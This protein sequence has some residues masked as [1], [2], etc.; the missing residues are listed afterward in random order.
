MKQKKIINYDNI[1]FHKFKLNIL[2]YL[3]INWRRDIII[4]VIIIIII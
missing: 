4:I 3:P 1:I 2:L